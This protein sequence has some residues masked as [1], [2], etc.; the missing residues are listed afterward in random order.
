M[1]QRRL[2][3]SVASQR[4]WAISAF[5]I[6][7]ALIA[8]VIAWR[9]IA[10][11]VAPGIE[12][13]QDRDASR[14]RRAPGVVR[15]FSGPVLNSGPL[16]RTSSSSPMPMA[17]ATF[18]AL[19]C[20]ISW[21][22]TAPF[23]GPVV[24]D[25]LITEQRRA[26][27]ALRG[28]S[29]RSGAPSS[30]AA[31]PPAASLVAERDDLRVLARRASRAACC[32]R[33]LG[34]QRPAARVF[35]R[36]TSSS[37]AGIRALSGTRI[38]PR[39]A[40]ANSRSSSSGAF[41]PRYATR[42]PSAIAAR[43]ASAPASRATRRSSASQVIST[44]LEADRE[45]VGRALGPVGDPAG[46]LLLCAAHVRRGIPVIGRLMLRRVHAEVRPLGPRVARR[47]ARRPPGQPR[48]GAGTV[49]GHGRDHGARPQPARLDPPARA[50]RRHDLGR[51]RGGARRRGGQRPDGRQRLRHLA[52]HRARL[53]RD[54]LLRAQ[55]GAL[56]VRGRV[57][58]RLR[59][60]GAG[61]GAT[62]TSSS[63]WTTRT[64][65]TRCARRCAGRRRRLRR[66]VADG[67]V[68][69]VVEIGARVAAEDTHAVTV[70]LSPGATAAVE[71]LCPG[72][73]ELSARIE[74]QAPPG[75]LV[76][77]VV[78]LTAVKAELASPG[79]GQAVAAR[80]RRHDHAAARRDPGG[81]RARV[82]TVS[83][84]SG[85]RRRTRRRACRRRT[86]V[87]RR[88]S[89]SADGAWEWPACRGR[90]PRRCAASAQRRPTD[91]DESFH[92]SVGGAGGARLRAGAA[93]DVAARR[94]RRECRGRGRRLR[95]RVA[96]VRTFAIGRRVSGGVSFYSRYTPSGRTT[97]RAP[98]A[99]RHVGGGGPFYTR[100][101][102]SD[103][104]PPDLPAFSAGLRV[105]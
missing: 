22:S 54:P 85:P 27:R 55:R 61:G 83:R 32:E 77:P 18:S 34:E 23:V 1:T 37:G 75:E 73:D 64:T 12:L 88:R 86:S 31:R 87:R 19:K 78:E 104:H 76:K 53:P 44:I 47:L 26:Q 60:G 80:L 11:S 94:A 101:T 102:R 57:P 5:V 46:D 52:D 36:T 91:L 14:R 62:T 99:M 43:S 56:R 15:M 7:G 41:C 28:R 103:R 70:L 24:P 90:E 17:A 84:R 66:R 3:R 95:G 13:A 38:A 69:L 35:C 92:R 8:S 40:H 20:S 105:P 48:A 16:A 21:V 4:G 71:E 72:D 93:R 51:A 33:R 25:V 39:R 98:V 49:G 96:C 29:A 89:A 2:E 67:A 6:A 42:S 79:E 59:A 74:A 10:S 68:A 45:R 50:E 63:W 100:Y 81:L 30:S 65:P 9:S 97:P 82:A 58:A